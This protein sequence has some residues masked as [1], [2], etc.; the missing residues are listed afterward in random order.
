MKLVTYMTAEGNVSVGSVHNDR[1]IDLVEASSGRLPADMRTLLELGSPALELAREIST[2]AVDGHP[3]EAIKLLAPIRNPSKIIAI[4]LNYMDHCREQGHEPP[5]TPKVFA[6]FTTAVVGPGATICWDPKL[7]KQV[8]YEAELAVV[9]GR[10]ARRV[11]EA[12]ALG[13]VAGYTVCNEVSARDLQFSD[14]QWVRG[15]TLDTFCPL[16]PWLVTRDEIPNPHV[17]PIRCTVNE[18]VLQDS[19]TCELIFSIPTL[20]E[21]CSRAFTLLPGDVIIT[22]TPSGV[23]VFRN[24]PIFLTDGDTVTVEIEGIGSLM[25]I[26]A[27]E[28]MA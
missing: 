10:I 23:G 6:K 13:H 17:L 24:P 7:T 3:L 14:G 25:N 9:I 8:D 22:G 28:D 12:D 18:Q 1:V 27:E 4:G 16:G 11:S 15:K 21:F 26:C 19:N 5:K 20:V 2:A